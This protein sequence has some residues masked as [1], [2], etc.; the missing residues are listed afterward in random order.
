MAAFGYAELIMCLGGNGYGGFGC[1]E[2]IMCFGDGGYGGVG[3]DNGF[4]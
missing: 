2:L 3:I 4:W 1:S